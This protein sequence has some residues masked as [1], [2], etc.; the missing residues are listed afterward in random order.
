MTKKENEECCFHFFKSAIDNIELPKQ[1]TDPFNEVPH[2][3][4][5]IAAEEL[6]EF[7]MNQNEIDHDFGINKSTGIGKMFGVLVVKNTSNQ[8]GYLVGFSGKLQDELHPVQ[9]VPS[10][11]EANEANSF[12]SVGLTQV[13]AINKAISELENEPSFLK[14]KILIHTFKE[15]VISEIKL[16]TAELK[17]AKKVRNERRK[18]EQSKLSPIEFEQLKIE[19]AKESVLKKKSFKAY[20]RLKQE[21]IQKKE[22]LLKSIND[23]ITS[24]K[25]ARSTLSAQMQEQLFKNYA[26]LNKAGQYKSVNSIFA[27]VLNGRPPAAAGECATPKM[28]QY[29]YQHNLEPIAVAEFWWGKPQKAGLRKHKNFYPAC[30]QKCRP[31]LSYMLNL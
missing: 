10:I 23:E 1:F 6:M 13:T 16:L 31:I 14:N 9:F 12:L 3:I 21:E 29:A 15:T 25:K 7:L 24:L 8:L 4:A 28:L 17:A 11:F 2:K 27:P 30:E 19:L 18:T 22:S 26:F 5:R 20:V